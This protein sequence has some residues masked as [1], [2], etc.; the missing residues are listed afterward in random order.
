MARVRRKYKQPAGKPER[1]AFSVR[2]RAGRAALGWSQ[3][4]LG[5]RVGISQ[6]AVHH[7]EQGA[8]AARKSSKAAISE[9][10]EKHGLQFELL[11]DGDLKIVVPGHIVGGGQGVRR[12]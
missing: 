11:P 12:K 7:I 3:T 9:V 6:Q 8:V 2:V 10:F 5:N 1:E 4:Q